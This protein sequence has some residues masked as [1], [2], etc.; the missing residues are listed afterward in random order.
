[1]QELTEGRLGLLAGIEVVVIAA[2]VIAVLFHRLRQPSL[3]A[4]IFAGLGLG[5]T[6][7]SVFSGSLQSIEE[8]SHLGLVLL[9]FVIGLEM[10]LKGVFRHGTKIAT[11]AI[12]QTPLTAAVV[13][14]L[15]YLLVSLG[16]LLPGLGSS[17]A[18]HFYFAISIS[19]SSTAVVVRMLADKHDLKSKAGQVSLLTLIVQDV[20]AVMAI[21]YVSTSGSG[22]SSSGALGALGMVVGVLVVAGIIFFIADRV[23]SRLMFF[24]GRSSDLVGLAALGWCFLCAAGI[25]SVG[26]SAEMG[27]LLAGISLGR[28]R[29]AAEVLSKVSSLRD[30]FMALFFVALGMSLPA[31]SMWVLSSAFGLVVIV[32]LSR[33]ILYSVM[34]LFT[35]VG[36]IVAFATSL[37]LAQLSE[38]SL[39]L[40][41]LGISKG[42]LR[43]EE[44][45]VISYGLMISMLVSTYLIKYNYVLATGLN[46]VLHLK[47]TPINDVASDFPSKPAVSDPGA[48]RPE[49]VMLGYFHVADELVR[50]LK[51]HMPALLPRMLVID[52]NL[53]NHERIEANHLRVVYGDVS[54]LDTLRHHGIAEAKLV[55]CTIS[56]AFLRGT[57][58]ATLLNFTSSANPKAQFIATADTFEDTEKLLSQGAFACLC[59]PAESIPA[60]AEHISRALNR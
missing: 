13:F 16:I 17:R 53:A 48:H 41:P 47:S 46:R 33:L 34:L 26:L 23:F 24:L 60:L 30:F 56:D 27:A 4:F 37:N 36:P 29:V 42:D 52:F 51:A 2:V 38:F 20:F 44:G 58:N 19:L 28:T 6:V 18:S 55:L 50:Y 11:A 59:P 1:M 54:N 35:G 7:R 5:L 31:P 21:S 10:D 40:V 9:L 43:V 14:G 22:E 12:L 32:L 8:V 15:Q 57:T 39:L 45:A 49:I 3:L 25:S